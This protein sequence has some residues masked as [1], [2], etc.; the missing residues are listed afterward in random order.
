MTFGEME[1]THCKSLFL[2]MI[3][4]IIF[5]QEESLR[6][7]YV[8]KQLHCYLSSNLFPDAFIDYLKIKEIFMKLLTPG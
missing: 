8:E 2:D 6:G 1:E 7:N 5:A 3:K 4:K